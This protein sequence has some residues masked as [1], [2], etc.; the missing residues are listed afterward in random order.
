MTIRHRRMPAPAAD[1]DARE[2]SSLGAEFRPTHVVPLQAVALGV[3]FVT[4]L[5]ATFTILPFAVDD[6]PFLLKIGSGVAA[7]LVLISWFGFYR[8]WKTRRKFAHCILRLDHRSVFPGRLC[9]F[10]IE[11]ERDVLIN[12]RFSLSYQDVFRRKGG[13]KPYTHGPF[14]LDVEVRSKRS[15]DHGQLGV[16]GEFTVHA[17]QIK[18]DPPD[19]NW[20]T[21][22]L[23]RLA[24]RLPDGRGCHFE[25][26]YEP[27]PVQG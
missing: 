12:P 17:D 7:M 4:V 27:H 8:A 22:T 24:L 21:H 19:A 26:P 11:D 23:V 9:R 13:R 14:V 16:T 3:F 25:L 15:G 5:G 20:E 2:K 18:A 1:G 6:A 10:V